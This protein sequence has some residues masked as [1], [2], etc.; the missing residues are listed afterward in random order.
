MNVLSLFDGVSCG[1]VALE[2]VGIRVDKYYASEIDE[3]AI[4]ISKKN[5]P[6]II[7][8]GDITNW[9]N[10]D[11]DW[12][13][14]D[15]V[16]GGS[17][18]QG[19]SNA[20]RGLNF[21][22][23]RSALFFV[24]VEILN[25]I[26]EFNKDVMFLL[27]NVK[28]K[29]EWVDTISSFLGVEPVEINSSLVSAQNRQ[30]LYWTNIATITQPQDRNIY[31]KDILITQNT[32]RMPEY[33]NKDK[34]R[35]LTCHYSNN[36][37]GWYDRITDPNPNKQQIDVLATAINTCSNEKAHCI[38]AQYYKNSVANFVTNGG[39]GAT[40]I[41]EKVNDI[42]FTEQKTGKNVFEVKNKKTIIYD[43]EYKLNL[44]DGLW[45]FR[46]LTP[47][48]CERLQTLPDDY[49]K[50]DGVSN[51]QRYKCIGNGWTID[52]IAYIFSLIK[53]DTETYFV[54]KKSD[55]TY[56]RRYFENLAQFDEEL[57]LAEM[58]STR[59]SVESA[60]D[61]IIRNEYRFHIKPE[62]LSVV[63][64]EIKEVE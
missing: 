43:K 47:L 17:P 42:Y 51:T 3:Y 28:M 44:E 63:K 4:K 58:Y 14:I 36:F 26:K 59:Y 29:K 45:S 8:L 16:M 38:K 7:Q 48:E 1:M 37:G 21:D 10:W 11:I 53:K 2:R 5:Y 15:L 18:C 27:E 32:D 46:K 55:G 64:I 23:P 52:V 20:G 31:L 6:N 61:F 22:D 24:F 49:T 41:A 34:S 39:F 50:C 40:G 30:R 57:R 13:S 56:Y 54:I 35:P 33:G 62:D 12:S 9:K 19:F 60:K 25:H